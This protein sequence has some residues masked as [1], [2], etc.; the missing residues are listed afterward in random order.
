MTGASTEQQQQSNM[1]PTTVP[2][3]A[4]CEVST[5]ARTHHR[6]LV[7]VEAAALAV[8]ALTAL[9]LQLPCAITSHST[10]LLLQATPATTNTTCVITQTTTQ[11]HTHQSRCCIGNIPWCRCTLVSQCSSCRSN[12]RAGS[13]KRQ[14]SN[15]GDEGLGV[16]GEQVLALLLLVQIEEAHA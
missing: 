12:S 10:L 7:F 11:P 8:A 9:L 15:R 5:T 14:L 16:L 3:H 2:S 1:A 6:P 13:V 4:I